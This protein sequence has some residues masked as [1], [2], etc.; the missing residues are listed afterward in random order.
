MLFTIVDWKKL[1][2]VDT[3]SL[4]GRNADTKETIK[5]LIDFNNT[6]DVKNLTYEQLMY[7]IKQR[8]ESYDR[9][10]F[11]VMQSNCQETENAGKH[12]GFFEFDVTNT[13]EANCGPQEIEHAI[14]A[15]NSANVDQLTGYLYKTG[16]GY[17]FIAD[18]VFDFSDYMRVISALKCC[19]GFETMCAV[20]GFGG[21][22]L[23][24]KPNRLPD[25]EYFKRIGDPVYLPPNIIHVHDTIHSYL[26]NFVYLY[27]KDGT[28]MKPCYICD[29]YKVVGF[30]KNEDGSYKPFNY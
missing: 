22:R 28:T 9:E 2:A 17:H 26:H 18:Q 19:D 13:V 5:E 14:E 15:Y 10:F 30:E 20:N 11:V 12:Y 1:S 27:D 7:S 6:Y 24:Y 8:T 29:K 23:G 21:I 16:G 4:L 25:I 3:Q